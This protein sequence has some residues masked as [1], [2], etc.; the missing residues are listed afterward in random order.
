MNDSAAHPPLFR[1][2]RYGVTIIE[3]WFD[4]LPPGQ[5]RCDVLDYR[6]LSRPLEGTQTSPFHTL[7]VPLSDSTETIFD[8]MKK[9]TRRDIRRAEDRDRS[10]YA[11]SDDIAAAV[12]EFLA[13]DA[14]FARHRGIAPAHAEGLRALAAQQALALS[15][16]M[17]KGETLSWHVFVVGSGRARLLHSPSLAGD[18]AGMRQIIGRA[19]RF[20]HWRDMLH[21]RSRGAGSYDLGGWSGS[22]EPALARIDRFKE[23]FGGRLIVEYNCTATPTLLGRSYDW[24]RKVRSRSG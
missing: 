7:I 9:N 22:A 14:L 16:V 15:R 10:E 1:Y 20:H 8:L 6:Q 24:L 23:E 19:N 13:F 17:R 18:D 2:R 3:A 11:I 21:F 5:R 12:S 4:V